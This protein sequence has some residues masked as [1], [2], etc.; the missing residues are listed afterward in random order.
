MAKF[1]FFITF[2]YEGAI[3]RWVVYLCMAGEEQAL[4]SHGRR[5]EMAQIQ[6]GT[7]AE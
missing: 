3:G 1:T 7:A 4:N 2:P 6:G 5:V